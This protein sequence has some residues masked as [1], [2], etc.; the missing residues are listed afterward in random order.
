MKTYQQALKP[1]TSKLKKE[2]DKIFVD[3]NKE[4]ES[5]KIT[6]T[7]ESNKLWNSKYSKKF[8]KTMKSHNIEAIKIYNEYHKK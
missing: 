5:K 4:K 6:T 1:V 8:D 3:F 7:A 2:T